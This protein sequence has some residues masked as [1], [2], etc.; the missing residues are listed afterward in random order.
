MK[1]RIVKLGLRV[2]ISIIFIMFLLHSTNILE[3]INSLIKSNHKI[4]TIGIAVYV[5]GQI[6]SAYKWSLLTKAAGFKKTLKEH[7]HLYFTGMFFN[8]FLPS[9][10]GGDVTR[11]YYLSKGETGGKRRVAYTVLAERFTGVVALVLMSTVAAFTSFGNPLPTFIKLFLVLLSI[12][13]IVVPL[14]FRQICSMLPDNTFFIKKSTINRMLAD[15]KV[16]W[17]NPKLIF[18]ALYWSFLFHLLIIAIHIL[19]AQAMKVNIPVGY[20]FI[21]YPLTSIAGFLP[22]SFNGIGPREG[23]YIYLLSLIAIKTPVALAFSIFWFGIV[24]FSSLIGGIFYIK[25]HHFPILEAEVNQNE[26][27]EEQ[28]NAE[29]A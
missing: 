24:F 23:M 8:L 17:E 1:S 26:E 10:V 18:K 14:V 27:I 19:I 20:Y 6:V 9:T 3:I 4:W 11:C 12:T 15:T 21:L 2:G 22:V 16:Y 28:H 7:I 5:F 13:V 29:P 25:G